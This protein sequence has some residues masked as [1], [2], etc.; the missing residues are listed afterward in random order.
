[1]VDDLPMRATD[2]TGG[3]SG[4][5]EAA[6]RALYERTARPLWVYIARATGDD[7]L[8]DDLLQEAYY[9]LLRA[10]FEPESDDHAKN[11]LFR[12]ATNLVRDHFRG[13]KRVPLPLEIE[14]GVVGHEHQVHLQHDLRK[15]MLQLKPRE[16]E[17]LWLGH[18]E[19][20]SHKEIAAIL[21]LKPGSIRLLLFR[22]RQKLAALLEEPAAGSEDR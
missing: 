20:F 3:A 1:V 19:R 11:Y 17:L 2:T 7:S 16:R 15:A 6:F 5:D 18:V 10:G 14:P 22:A 12:I 13:A 9:R 8:A 21:G 4:L